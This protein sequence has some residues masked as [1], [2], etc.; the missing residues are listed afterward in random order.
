MNKSNL[1][2]QFAIFLFSC[3]FIISLYFFI[4]KEIAYFGYF[5][6]F[7]SIVV[8]SIFFVNVTLFSH[9]AKLWISL[10]DHLGQIFNPI[11]LGILFFILI[12]PI[13]L[14]TRIFG[15][16][17]LELKRSRVQSYWIYKNKLKEN[18]KSFYRQF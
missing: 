3:F 15:R 8:V 9:S 4:I 14:I 12:T 17:E 18:S 13:S 1:N 11:A 7:L 6:L 10:G 16:D 2:S 5:F